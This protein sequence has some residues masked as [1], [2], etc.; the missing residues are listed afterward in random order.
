MIVGIVCHVEVLKLNHEAIVWQIIL[1]D[2]YSY[3]TKLIFGGA[4]IRRGLYTDILGDP[5][6]VSWAGRKGAAKV[7]KHARKLLP[8]LFSLP[9][10]LPLGLRGWYTEGNLPPPP[11]ILTGTFSGHG[12]L[13]ATFF[14]LLFCSMCPFPFDKAWKLFIYG[15]N[16]FCHLKIAGNWCSRKAE[17]AISETLYFKTFRR[18][19]P[20]DPPSSSRPRRSWL[21]PPL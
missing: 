8:H 14:T 6:A 1:P 4:Y 19:M 10:W 2:Y 5:G 21:P 17:N 11:I 12:L 18:S 20:S 16:D 15:F 13:A 3:A 7:F 9:D